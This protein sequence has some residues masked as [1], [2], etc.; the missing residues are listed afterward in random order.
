MGELI[1][2]AFADFGE[3]TRLISFRSTVAAMPLASLA[4]TA[5]S[6]VQ[7]QELFLDSRGELPTVGGQVRVGTI[8][9]TQGFNW[10]KLDSN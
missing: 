6:L 8:T 4:T 2:D 1:E 3:K 7:I 5:K 10:V 9:K